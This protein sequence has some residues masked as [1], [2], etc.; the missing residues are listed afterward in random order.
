MAKE[1]PLYSI[2]VR[3]IFVV[4]VLL[5]LAGISFCYLCIYGLAVNFFLVAGDNIAEPMISIDRYLGFLLSFILPFGFSFDL[6]VILYVTTRIG[7]T[8]PRMLIRKFKYVILIIFTAA[9][10]LTPPDVFSQI[11]LALPLLALYWAGII[12]SVFACRKQKACK[13]L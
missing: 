3:A 11:M 4:T 7:L 10:I 12:V 5:F 8:N 9:A 2:A 13:S 6:P 1:V